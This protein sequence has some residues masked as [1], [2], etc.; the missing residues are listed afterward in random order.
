MINIEEP[1]GLGPILAAPVSS[2]E[3][4]TLHMKWLRGVVVSVALL[5]LVAW[6]LI[7]GFGF[8]AV[9]G[10]LYGRGDSLWNTLAVCA[11]TL[12]FALIVGGTRI[13]HEIRR[14]PDRRLSPREQKEY[15][16]LANINSATRQFDEQTQQLDRALVAHDLLTLRAYRHR[17]FKHLHA[18]LREKLAM[19]PPPDHYATLYRFVNGQQDRA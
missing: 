11:D 16:A 10:Y 6:A 12:C 2:R 18:A 1:I 15:L 19:E 7:H 17:L 5:V 13:V 3:L 9:F 8:R 14:C 4:A